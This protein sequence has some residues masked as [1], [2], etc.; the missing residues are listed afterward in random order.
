M[1]K[2]GKILLALIILCAVLY[3]APFIVVDAKDGASTYKVPFASSFLTK[4][5]ETITFTNIR[6]SYAVGK[7]AE[8][9]LHAYEEVKCYGNTYYYDKGNDITFSGY[10]VRSGMPTRIIYKY[11]DGNKCKGW[12][13]D[14]EIAFKDG[15]PLEVDPNITTQQAME[16]NW[17]VVKDG[18]SLN[19]PQYYDFAR[20]VKQGVYSMQR[21]LIYEGDD[22]TIIDVQVLSDARFKV[23][24]V[25]DGEKDIEYYGRFTETEVDGHK[26]A[27]VYYGLDTE[28]KPRLLYICE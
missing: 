24:T 19:L 11:E 18:K 25:K 13:V 23:T 2:G 26:Y 17:Y 4:D 21:T 7:D 22:L 14:D 28:E 15:D 16:N 6:S 8:N 9:S 1:K 10:E 20:M 27:G 5:N 12:T 3:F